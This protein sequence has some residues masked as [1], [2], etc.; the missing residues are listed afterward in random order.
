MTARERSMSRA[1]AG[2]RA[3]QARAYLMVAEMVRTDETI[4]VANN[5]VGSLAVL[6]GIAAADAITGT[7]LKRRTAGENHA[8]AIRLLERATPPEST[9]AASLRRLLASKTDTQ[10]S[11]ELVSTTKAGELLASA[12]KLVREMERALRG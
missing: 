7:T 4:S 10:Y 11:P 12:R 6:A 5:L 2:T 3:E 9:I 8:D 1:E